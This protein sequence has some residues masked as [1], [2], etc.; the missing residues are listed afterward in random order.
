MVAHVERLQGDVEVRAPALVGHL[1]ALGQ[2]GILR[3]RGPSSTR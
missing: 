2:S 1:A 3:P